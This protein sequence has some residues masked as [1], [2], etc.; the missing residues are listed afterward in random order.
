M[1]SAPV[2]TYPHVELDEQDVPIIVGTTMKVVELVMAQ[3]AHGWSPEELHFQHPY[4]SMSQVYGA[5]TYYWD[6]KA[7]LD[8]DIA[9]RTA[10]VEQARNEAPASPLAARLREKNRVD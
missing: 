7:E 9:A 10:Y 3:Q 6:H 1:Q 8:A 2:V 4:L 5:L